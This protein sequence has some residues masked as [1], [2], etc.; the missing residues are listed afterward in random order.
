MALSIAFNGSL[1][2][3]LTEDAR[4]QAVPV[5]FALTYTKKVMYDFTNNLGVSHVAVPQGVVNAPT[6][7]LVFVKEGEIELSWDSMGANPTSIKAN[8]TQTPPDV[9]VMMLAR[10]QPGAGQLYLT[11]TGVARGA[12]W[13]FQ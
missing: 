11:S 5:N 2:L 3:Q 8:P 7:I 6:F 1:L 10:Y 9:P 13:L 4:P 12:I